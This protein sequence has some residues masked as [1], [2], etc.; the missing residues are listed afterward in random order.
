ML[1]RLWPHGSSVGVHLSRPVRVS[2]STTAAHV[3][4][5][6]AVNYAMTAFVLPGGDGLATSGRGDAR[7]QVFS[8]GSRSR[9]VATMVLPSPWRAP[10]GKICAAVTIGHRLVM[11][12]AVRR[13]VPEVSTPSVLGRTLSQETRPVSRRVAAAL[14]RSTS[15]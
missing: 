11:P 7:P 4:N 5:S 12:A 10:A 15:L 13:A 9:T 1:P 6:C 8:G 2:L 3:T 14:N